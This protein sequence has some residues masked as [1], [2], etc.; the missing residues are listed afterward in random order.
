MLT[1]TTECYRISSDQYEFAQNCIRKGIHK[2][3]SVYVRAVLRHT[4]PFELCT[5]LGEKV[6]YNPSE[7]RIDCNFKETERKSMAML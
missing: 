7:K 5:I 2:R 4:L 1:T 3:N 6:N